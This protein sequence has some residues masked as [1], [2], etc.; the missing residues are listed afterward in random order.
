M[1]FQSL[2]GGYISVGVSDQSNNSYQFGASILSGS[3]PNLII[4]YSSTTWQWAT[5]DG[6]NGDVLTT[7]GSGNLSFSNLLKINNVPSYANDAA[8]ISGGL[9]TGNLYKTTTGGITALNIV[10]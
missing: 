10:P 1:A 2:S 5:K 9:T 6:Q 8:A 3:V 4:Q 7:D